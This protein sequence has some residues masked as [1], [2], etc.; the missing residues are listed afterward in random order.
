MTTAELQA[1]EGEAK[2]APE[3]HY[4]HPTREQWLA[5]GIKALDA[6]YF[7]DKGYELPEKLQC[8]CG[9]CRGSSKAIGQCWDPKVTPDGTTHMFICPT[10]GDPVVVLAT[11]LHELIHAAIGVEEKHGKLFKKLC[12]EMG[13]AGK[14]TATYAEAGSPLHA[15]LLIISEKLGPYPHSPMVKRVKSGKKSMGGWIRLRSVNEEGYKVLI[16]P[17]QLEEHGYPVD[18]F[19]DEMVPVEE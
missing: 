16:S 17:R 12:K 6:R 9:W 4:L 13:L 7:D 14:A 2:P 15:E 5:A 11:L 18:P 3:V 8:S 10:L 1:P 19:G